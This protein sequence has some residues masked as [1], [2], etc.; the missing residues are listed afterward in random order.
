MKYFPILIEGKGGKIHFPFE[1]LFAEVQY[2]RNTKARYAADMAYERDI[3]CFGYLLVP[4]L[5]LNLLHEHYEMS[6]GV[7]G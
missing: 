2:D 6:T 5:N 3:Q 7:Q 4:S 1:C